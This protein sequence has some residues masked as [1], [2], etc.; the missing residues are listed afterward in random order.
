MDYGNLYSEDGDLIYS[1]DFKNDKYEGFGELHQEFD[2][3]FQV[4]EGSLPKFKHEIIL[5]K[6]IGDFKG[7]KKMEMELY[8]IEMALQDMKGNL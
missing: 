3:L 5:E 1:G 2:V 7:G 8:L 4:S 6:Y